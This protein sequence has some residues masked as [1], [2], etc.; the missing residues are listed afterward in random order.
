MSRLLLSLAA[1]AGVFGSRVVAEEPFTIDLTVSVG[2]ASKAVH[3]ESAAPLAKH[4]ERETL[5]AKAGARITVKWKLVNVDPKATIKDVT[6]HF[7]AAQAENAGQAAIKN[8]GKAVVAESA[9]N[10]DFTPK[11]TNEG[12]LNFSIDKP[13]LYLLRLETIG[14]VAGPGGHEEFAA[15][16]VRVK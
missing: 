8:L 13:G 1:L 4:K 2:K 3:A 14:A 6:V 12:E 16:D 5:D 15:L 9:L 7:Y 10:M 11:E